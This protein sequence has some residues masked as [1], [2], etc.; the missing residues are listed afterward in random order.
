M[1]R[2]KTMRFLNFTTKAWSNKITVKSI[3]NKEF[4]MKLLKMMIMKNQMNPCI[5]GMNLKQKMIMQ[6]Q[7]LSIKLLIKT[8]LL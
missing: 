6:Q 2:T 4:K 3:R 7:T 5:K 8:V 1:L